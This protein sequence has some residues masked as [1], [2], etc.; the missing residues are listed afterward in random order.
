M[1]HQCVFHLFNP[2]CILYQNARKK[3]VQK[4]LTVKRLTV[5]FV[6][7]TQTNMTPNHRTQNSGRSDSLSRSWAVRLDQERTDA[8]S[9]V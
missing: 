2:N 4:K 7:N 8:I 5:T 3:K 6:L 1:S 9:A